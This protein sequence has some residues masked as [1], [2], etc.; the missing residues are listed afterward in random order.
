MLNVT[1]L[2]RSC[3]LSRSTILYYESVGL[4][5]PARRT[6]SQYRVYGDREAE[7]LRQIR[8]YRDAGLTLDDIR[9]LL[10]GSEGGHAFA[11]LQ[12]R[13]AAIG[14]EIERL[15][16]HQRCILALLRNKTRFRRPG[17]MTKDKW[18]TIMRASGFTDDDMHRW[19]REF[20]KA[21][22]DDHQEFLSY[23]KIPAEEIGK[24]REWSRS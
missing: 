8:T 11:V 16:E 14:S 5:R 22:P 23:L 13:L 17:V 12:R 24:I 9:A 4:L 10:D 18:V 2:A 20:E 6:A 19:H 1:E 3:G 21:A 15:R 7:R